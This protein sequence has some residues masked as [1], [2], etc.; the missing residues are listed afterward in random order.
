MKM[1]KQPKVRI[2]RPDKRPIQLR[3]MCPDEERQIRISTGTRDEAEALRQKQELEAKLLL[4][5]NAKPRKISRSPNM[6]WEEFREEYTRLKVST[7]RSEKAM[8]ASEIRLDVCQAVIKPRTLSDL[9]SREV[10]AQLQAE[11]LAGS[12][13]Q[14]KRRRSPRTVE[15]YMRSLQSALNWAYKMGWLEERTT[16]DLLGIDDDSFEALQREIDG[17]RSPSPTALQSS[18]VSGA[19][20]LLAEPKKVAAR[21]VAGYL[22]GAHKWMLIAGHHDHI[23]GFSGESDTTYNGAD[24]NASGTSLVLE[25]AE[26][27]ASKEAG[28]R[29]NLAFATFSAEE[30]GLF[31]SRAF[32]RNEWLD[33]DSVSMMINIDMVGR[34]ADAPISIFGDGF[35]SGVA[36]ILEEISVDFS[37]GIDLQGRAHEP[38]SDHDVFRRL[39]IPFVMFHT[40]LHEDYHEVSDHPEL[41]DYRRM[42][43]IGVM[44]A[45]FIERVME[46]DPQPVW[47]DER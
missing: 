22:E 18:S 3:Y 36:E 2:V 11:L 45:R 15:S 41:I 8:R 4:G 29:W 46:A 25:L 38:M 21:N 37:G 33:L 9:S 14:R 24:D 12:L 34:N 23:G 39:E 17:G 5:I 13:S 40:G 27:F 20:A 7:F 35:V 30:V 44:I 19:V 43:D 28:N 31:G 26:Y 42:S 32:E 10:L 6:R 1:K 16:L 47:R